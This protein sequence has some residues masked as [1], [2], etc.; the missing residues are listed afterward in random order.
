L[1]QELQGVIISV[2]AE[3]KR[4]EEQV[5]SV[6]EMVSKLESIPDD[7]AALKATTGSSADLLRA[8]SAQVDMLLQEVTA[9]AAAHEIVS[10]VKD[11]SAVTAGTDEHQ[12][13][14]ARA[15]KHSTDAIAVVDSTATKD[16]RASPLVASSTLVQKKVDAHLHLHMQH[17]EHGTRWAALGDSIKEEKIN[18]N[19]AATKMR[20][21]VDSELETLKASLEAAL[22]S[23]VSG[24]RMEE[25]EGTIAAINKNV[26]DVTESAKGAAG[27]AREA[28]RNVYELSKSNGAKAAEENAA[29]LVSLDEKLDKA[30]GDLFTSTDVEALV[31]KREQAL[32]SSIDAKA[33]LSDLTRS[34]SLITGLSERVTYLTKM[35]DKLDSLNLLIDNGKAEWHE[36]LNILGKTVLDKADQSWM[37]EFEERLRAELM[38]LIN[39]A[40]DG[41]AGDTVTRREFDRKIAGLNKKVKAAGQ[42]GESSSDGSRTAM[43]TMPTSS[44][45]RCIACDAPLT[46]PTHLTD[47]SVEAAK[48]LYLQNRAPIAAGIAY[49]ESSLAG[50][51]PGSALPPRSLTP[52]AAVGDKPYG[53]QG[54]ETPLPPLAGPTLPSA[55]QGTYVRGFS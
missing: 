6:G 45:F 53:G 1:E 38:A 27:E 9:E 5:K 51:D 52:M 11:V 21:E 47:N 16:A 7:I 13:A 41:N 2:K 24:D 10:S 30:L 44:A 28:S 25:L 37:E 54:F 4:V 23:M 29:A 22:A 36:Q 19:I 46:K 18:T 17:I 3:T 55:A 14:M 20:K 15:E 43:P 12:D 32:K 49:S 39:G 48:S 8:Q 50:V 40:D 42:R 31:D 35:Q 26:N 33:D 34:T